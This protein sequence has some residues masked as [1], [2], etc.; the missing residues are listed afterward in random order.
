MRPNAA[1]AAGS[2][3]GTNQLEVEAAAAKGGG[4]SI[5]TDQLARIGGYTG[6]N[7]G[8]TIALAEQTLGV[9]KQMLSVLTGIG[10][11]N[12]QVAVWGV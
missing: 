10:R 1:A 8:R 11:Q 6:G 5:A 7:T 4:G 12:K 9:N 2:A 3:L